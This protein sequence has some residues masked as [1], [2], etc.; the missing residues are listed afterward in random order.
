MDSQVQLHR[1]IKIQICYVKNRRAPKFNF[2][3][4]DPQ[5]Q[6]QIYQQPR[7]EETELHSKYRN[8]LKK[9]VKSEE[10]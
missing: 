7:I 5:Y 9:K 4:L 2:H 1:L 3:H 8:Y 10:G 6:E